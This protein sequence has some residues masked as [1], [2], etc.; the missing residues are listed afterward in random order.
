MQA[1]LDAR[2]QDGARGGKPL[3]PAQRRGTA[4]LNQE[5]S[6]TLESLVKQL[7]VALV[8]AAMPEIPA[9]LAAPWVT[10][11]C[12][13]AAV[14]GGRSPEGARERVVCARCV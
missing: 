3:D 8:N 4:P 12:L 5:E 13:G 9:L 6:P 1:D 14:C 11:R 10:G 7:A 2:R